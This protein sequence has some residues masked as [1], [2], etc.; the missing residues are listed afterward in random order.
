MPGHNEIDSERRE[1]VRRASP[2]VAQTMNNPSLPTPDPARPAA[3][4]A[5]LP[6]DRDVLISRLIDSRASDADWHAVR[7][8]ALSDATIWTDIALSQRQASMLC[9]VAAPVLSAAEA[10]AMPLLDGP[11]ALAR[12]EGLNGWPDRLS[13]MRSSRLGWAIAAMLALAWGATILAPAR[14]KL[15]GALKRWA[16]V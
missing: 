6:V 16:S 15:A 3:L 9:A 7:A 1:S 5:A 12:L 11:P 10:T 13:M 14:P 4:P 8:I 2:A